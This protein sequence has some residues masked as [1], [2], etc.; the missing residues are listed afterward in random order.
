MNPAYI[1]RQIHEL[2]REQ[3]G[4][5]G[6]ITSLLPIRPENAPDD[7]EKEA[8]QA[9]ERGEKEVLS[10]EPLG[11]E[12]YLRLI[13]PMIT[14][15]ACLKCHASQGYK[16][17]DIRGGISV[18]VLW[19]PF[20]K[21]L[22]TQ[23]L[24]T[25]FAYS[26]IWIVG[27]LGLW[28]GWNQIKNYLSERKKM[29]NEII[30]LSITDQLTGLYNRRGFLSLSE[31]QLKLSD[32]KK[33]GMEL[34]FAD[35]DGLKQIN[36]TLGHEEGDK[37]LIETADVL[38]ETFRASDIIARLGG[39]EFAVLA[40]DTDEV[41]SGIFPVRLQQLIDRQNNQKGRKYSL[42]ISIGCSH[43]DPENPSTIDELMERADKLMY[44]EKQR[45]RVKG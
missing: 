37:S 21:G 13:Y 25:V 29:E 35:L 39:D 18:S 12:I 40:I 24:T 4:L 32:R 44:E 45:K 7:W 31:Q 22:L 3:Y 23:L 30:A 34:F 33:K 14:E 5:R 38:K 11:E 36:D 15:P 8:L 20:Q 43:Y 17:G 9:F 42:S 28:F 6:H 1:T 41:V 19:R 2:G 27:L 16:S 10:L 26:A